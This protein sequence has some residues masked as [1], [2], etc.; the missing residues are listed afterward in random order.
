MPVEKTTRLARFARFLIGSKPSQNKPSQNKKSTLVPND[1]NHDPLGSNPDMLTSSIELVFTPVL[2]FG[3][4]FLVDHHFHTT[5]IFSLVGVLFGAVGST[6]RLYYS[7]MDRREN[8]IGT[9]TGLSASI[10]SRL[11]LGS[12]M[13]SNGSLLFLEGDT[14]IPEELRLLAS[15]LDKQLEKPKP[16]QG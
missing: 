1:S 8:S 11:E 9:L 5:P 7:L 12:R 14:E 10:D 16:D 3:V 6:L 13:D 4:G 2:L 15:V